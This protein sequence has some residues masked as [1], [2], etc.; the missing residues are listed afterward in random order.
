M[1]FICSYFKITKKQTICSR[2][3]IQSISLSSL[4]KTYFIHT[5][6][7]MYYDNFPSVHTI[8]TTHV[9]LFIQSVSQRYNDFTFK[10]C[11]ILSLLRDTSCI[12]LPRCV[13]RFAAILISVWLH[14]TRNDI[15]QLS[16]VILYGPSYSLCY[17]N[18]R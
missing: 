12:F 5:S 17:C 15:I 13:M 1:D 10:W 2:I 6:Y 9:Y 8:N 14:C 18:N 16:K 11:M 3:H 7:W 4:H